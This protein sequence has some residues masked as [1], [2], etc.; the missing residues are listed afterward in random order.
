MALW[1]FQV[2][3]GILL[4][5]LIQLYNRLNPFDNDYKRT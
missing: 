4:F 3:D 5:A 2:L 1:I